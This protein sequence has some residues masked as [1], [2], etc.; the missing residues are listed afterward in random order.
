MKKINSIHFGGKMIAAGIGLAVIIPAVSRLAAGYFSWLLFIPGGAVLLIF[1]IIFG[2]E[3]HQD[4]SVIPHYEK[5]LKDT[6]PYNPQKH[7]PVIRASICTGEKTAGFRDRETGHF[8][9]VMI[10]HDEYDKERFRN[11]YGITDIK[12]EY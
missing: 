4:N 1:I 9:E 11:I 7:I 10:I 3:M 6:I 2:I 5:T 12:T 8:T